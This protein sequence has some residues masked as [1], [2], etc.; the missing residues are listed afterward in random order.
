MTVNIVCMTVTMTTKEKVGFRC[1]TYGQFYFSDVREFC[2]NEVFEAECPNGNI[3]MMDSAKYGRM[4]IGR[5][6]KV[7]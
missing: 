6:V 7:S 4:E 2:H 1:K 3:I 5:C